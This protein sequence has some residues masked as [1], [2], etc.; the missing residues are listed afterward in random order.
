MARIGI[1]TVLY[2][3]ETV[4]KDF[5][6]SLDK[7]TY[8]DFILY[9]IDNK[10]PDQ[11]LNLS[12]KLKQQVSFETKIIENQENYGIAKGN[13][14]GIIQALADNCEYVLLSNNDIELKP[15]AIEKLLTG[16]EQEKMNLAVPKIY[17][18]GTD[19]IWAVGGKFKYIS[20]GT[21]HLG[22]H[23]KD[24]SKWDKRYKV[25]YSPTC[26]MLIRSNIF[27]N[28]GLMDEAYFVYY[29]D[30]DFIYRCQKQKEKIIYIPESIIYHKES[31]CTGGTKSDFTLYYNA[32]NAV[33]F[34][35]K[36]FS[37]FHCIITTIAYFLY[38]WLVRRYNVL[39]QQRQLIIK[40]YKDGHQMY[41]KVYK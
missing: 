20:G 35:L 37:I 7:Q 17:F 31:T 34:A 26:F 29:D 13:N 40:G 2:G 1:V 24:D 38:Y 18:H 33:Y 21:A 5:F 32:R 8:K 25:S 11:S 14:I 10:S 15:D 4:L 27:Y 30:T 28:I 3:S 19:L 16:M 9:V 22:Y 41:K 23:Q 39:P 36:N 12:K 6:E